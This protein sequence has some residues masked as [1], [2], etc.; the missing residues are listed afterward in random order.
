VTLAR[1]QHPEG[2]AHLAVVI[3][4]KDAR[5]HGAASVTLASSAAR[6]STRQPRTA[7]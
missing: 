4:N 5:L 7:S 3:D 6:H 2:L 1:K